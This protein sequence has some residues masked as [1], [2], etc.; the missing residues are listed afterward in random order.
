MIGILRDEDMGDGGL[1]WDAALNEPGGRRR[2]HHYLLAGPAGVFRPARHDHAELGWHDVEALGH[3]F[4]D[5][6]QRAPAAGAGLV[7]D[8]DDLLEARQV[9]RQ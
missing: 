2:L 8:V 7:L 9:C 1:R 3:I 6:M 5:G 4:A